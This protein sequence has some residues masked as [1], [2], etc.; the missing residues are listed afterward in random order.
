MQ[1]C[2]INGDNNQFSMTFFLGFLTYG[3]LSTGFVCLGFVFYLSSVI[4]SLT[5]KDEHKKKQRKRKK[6]KE[7]STK[8]RR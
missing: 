1:Y 7:T 6:E 8:M 3:S 5:M 2:L 4:F